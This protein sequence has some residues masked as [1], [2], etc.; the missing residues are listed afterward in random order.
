MSPDL[1][2][3]E[4]TMEVAKPGS[5]RP[6]HE[7]VFRRTMLFLTMFLLAIRK[8]PLFHS[9][10]DRS[11]E[12]VVKRMPP[13]RGEP[14]KVK[15]QFTKGSTQLHPIQE[16]LAGDLETRKEFQ[17][18]LVS[19]ASAFGLSS[20]RILWSGAHL[21]LMDKPM[22]SLRDMRITSST[23]IVREPLHDDPQAD[24][25]PPSN[26]PRT[27][28]EKQIVAQFKEFYRL[29]DSDDMMSKSVS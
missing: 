28:F 3:E 12:N 15:C 16:V 24:T 13:I 11:M 25:V 4:D 23:L 21:K 18:R 29:M 14:I 20:F 26:Q 17:S 27:A 1:N 9:P 22:E 5:D 10:Q 7:L 6:N 19:L 2:G 8:Q